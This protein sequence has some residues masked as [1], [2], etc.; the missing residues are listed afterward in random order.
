[1]FSYILCS[2]SSNYNLGTFREDVLRNGIRLSC[3]PLTILTLVFEVMSREYYSVQTFHPEHRS[4][5]LAEFLYSRGQPSLNC[6]AHKTTGTPIAEI[7][8]IDRGR[9]SLIPCNRR[10]F[11]RYDLP[12]T[13]HHRIE[14]LKQKSSI[15]LPQ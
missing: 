13:R 15:A 4:D 12:I 1:M 6:R 8:N 10:H 11:G 5:N 9:G 3:L 14:H 2:H 7:R